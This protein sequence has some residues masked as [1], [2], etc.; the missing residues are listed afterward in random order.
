MNRI[1]MICVGLCIAGITA[2]GAWP[3]K[4]KDDPTKYVKTPDDTSIADAVPAES[5]APVAIVAE[6]TPAISR[7]S[8]LTFVDDAREAQFIKLAVARKRIRQDLSVLVRLV[9]EKKSEI[10]QFEVELE[11]DFAVNAAKNY[12]FD[13]DSG[14]IFELVG[15]PGDAAG[16]NQLART[17]IAKIENPDQ[18]KKFVRLV[19]SKNLSN[20]QFR[21]LSVI[22]EEKKIRLKMIE[23]ELA[24][25]FDI[26]PL[27][28]Y[29]YE[30]STK[31]VYEVGQPAPAASDQ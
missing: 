7:I 30:D 28:V 17:P 1:A 20:Q 4:S 21:M 16:T 31:T 29:E 27:K 5:V 22:E 3:F 24:K 9:D 13:Q 10:R 14:Q 2:E 8:H 25:D 6:S 23:D 15:N 19:A 26:D 12:E 18:Q 11:N